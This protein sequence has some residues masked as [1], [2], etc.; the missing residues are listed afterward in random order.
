MAILYA[1]VSYRGSVLVEHNEANGNFVE[2]ARKL[3]AKIPPNSRKVYSVENHNFH[4]ISENDLAFL[5]LC[6]ENFG[7]QLPFEFLM[8]IQGRFSRA[9]GNNIPYNAPQATFDPFGRVLEDRMK[10]YSNPQANKLN[11]VKDQVAEVRNE[12][13]NA[14]EKTI[15]RGEVIEVIVDKTEKLQSESFQFKANSTKLKRKLWWENKKLAIGIGIVVFV[16][17]GVIVI[18]VLKYFGIIG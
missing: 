9:Y 11:L 8:D 5:C 12:L 6:H 7:T 18:G 15:H 10:Y 3:L 13:T 4:Y 17:L 16:L 1:S 14:I 2:F